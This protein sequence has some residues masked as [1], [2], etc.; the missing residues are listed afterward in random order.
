MN[1]IARL[2]D[3]HELERYYESLMRKAEVFAAETGTAK[4]VRT[5]LV[6]PGGLVRNQYA[7]AVQS[8]VTAEDLFVP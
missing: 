3:W 6:T 7:D 2:K 4:S 8:V 5:T 1:L